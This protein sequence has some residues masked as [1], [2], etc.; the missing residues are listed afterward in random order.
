MSGPNPRSCLARFRSVGGSRVLRDDVLLCPSSLS[1]PTP[2]TSPSLADR[3]SRRVHGHSG[4]RFTTA[5]RAEFTSKGEVCEEIRLAR[6]Y[7]YTALANVHMS[8]PW[9]ASKL[10]LE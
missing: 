9:R 3:L 1:S 10:N 4:S 8:G 5:V 7:A 2:S 6:V